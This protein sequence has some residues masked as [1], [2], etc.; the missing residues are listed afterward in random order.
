MEPLVRFYI[1]RLGGERDGDLDSTSVRLGS[2]SNIVYHIQFWT[3]ADE[4]ADST[5]PPAGGACVHWRRA[6]DLKRGLNNRLPLAP[7]AWVQHVI[8]RWFSRDAQGALTRWTADVFDSGVTP[9]WRH[10]EPTADL[11]IESDEIKG[12][13][14]PPA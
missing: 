9:D 7:G 1:Q 13:P 12:A 11:I 10:Y 8:F 3:F 14:A 5:P 4:C 6:K 2:V